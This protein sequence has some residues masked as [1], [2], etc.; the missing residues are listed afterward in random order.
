MSAYISV[1]NQYPYEILEIHV[2]PT[3]FSSRYIARLH[4][5]NHWLV[6]KLMNERDLCE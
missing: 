3:M 1:I 4:N 5:R 2:D 6:V